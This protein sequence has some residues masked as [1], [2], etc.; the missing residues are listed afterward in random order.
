MVFSSAFFELSPV[1]HSYL[2][3]PSHPYGRDLTALA[4]TRQQPAGSSGF[5]LRRMRDRTR[6]S[7]LRFGLRRAWRRIEQ[8]LEERRSRVAD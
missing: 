1:C 6:F 7:H 2:Q 5:W 4:D 8:K 3:A